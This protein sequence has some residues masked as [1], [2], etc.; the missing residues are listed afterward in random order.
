M[1]ERP[2][3]WSAIV[4][5]STIAA[6]TAAWA[7]HLL[8]VADAQAGQLVSNIG[9]MCV[10]IAAGVAALA[11][12]WRAHSPQ[13]FWWL[14]G[15]ASLSWGAGQAVWTWYETVLGREVPFP[16]LA[17]VGYLGMPPLAAAAMLSLPL[18][19]PS[20]AGRVRTILDGLMVATSLLLV[21]WLLVLG[22]VIRAGGDSLVALIISLAYPVGDTVVI[23]IVLYTLLRARHAQQRSPAALPLV[24]IGLAAFALADSGFVYLTTSGLIAPAASSTSDGSLA[25]R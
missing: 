1:T 6:I 10:A 4:A 2:R 12:A 11:R 8:L 20:L 25:S 5:V 23:T 24:G 18:A 3:D 16:S 21:S 19:A 14:L 13:R 9:L 17:D 15:S 7:S 22:P